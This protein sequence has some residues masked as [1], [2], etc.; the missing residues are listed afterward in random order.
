MRINLFNQNINP[1]TN[2]GIPYCVIMQKK[3]RFYE[4]VL[5]STLFSSEGNRS[6]N[7]KAKKLKVHVDVEATPLQI[8]SRYNTVLERVLHRRCEL[9]FTGLNSLEASENGEKDRSGWRAKRWSF[10]KIA[11]FLQFSLSHTLLH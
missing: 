7:L 2:E 5:Q 6:N 1:K 10:L 4:T 3:N 9:L 8:D 11:T